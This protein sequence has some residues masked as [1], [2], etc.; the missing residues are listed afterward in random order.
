MR[1][2]SHYDR[3]LRND[4]LVITT[5]IA[6]NPGTPMIVSMSQIAWIL[7]VEI[8]WMGGRSPKQCCNIYELAIARYFV[9]SL[10]PPVV[11]PILCQ[12][13]CK[14]EILFIFYNLLTYLLCM[15]CFFPCWWYEFI[16]GTISLL[17]KEFPFP[18]LMMQI[19]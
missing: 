17:P 18:F 1:G 6:Q 7:V 10:W 3:Q 11:L 12:F 16:S 2:F 5:I 15:M 9:I 13:F 4:I 8:A 14:L 19:C